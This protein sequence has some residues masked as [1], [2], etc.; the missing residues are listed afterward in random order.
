[1]IT[2]AQVKQ[3]ALRLW[4][5]DKLLRAWL[6]CEALFPLVIG[7]GKPTATALL[8]DFSGV[9]AWKVDLEKHSQ[10]SIGYGYRIEYVDINHRQLGK[11][12][13][14]SKLVFDRPEDLIAYIKK[15]KEISRF[16]QL[17]GQIKNT[18]RKLLQWCELHP[19]KVLKYA[20]DWLRLLSVV[21]FFKE[22]PQPNRY[23]RELDIPL[24]DSKFIEK[25]KKIISQL[26]ERVLSP[27]DVD[28]CIQGMTNSGFERRF[29]LRYDQPNIRLRLLDEKLVAY[30]GGVSDLSIPL[31]QFVAMVPACKRVFITENKI[32]G[33]TFPPLSE[34][35]V[36]FGL[37]YGISL[38]KDIDWLMHRE[39]I[40]WGDIDTHGFAILSQLRAYYPQAKSMLMDLNT[41]QQFRSSWVVEQDSKRCLSVLPNLTPDEQGLLAA[42]KDNEFG[43]NIRLEQ[44]RVWFSTLLEYLNLGDLNR[45]E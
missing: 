45:A 8:N 33:L 41:L 29:G 12:R 36:I 14:P 38:L 42:L 15:G 4:Q 23:I 1:M 26:L 9:R 19:S 44:E 22:N 40:Y 43:H 16:S 17:L 21:S 10:C 28:Q 7:V 32:N 25:N 2:A 20:D 27:S 11:H 3:K 31:S 18:D 6:G 13:L 5:N 39:I 37:G 30:Y 24:V 34:S 35:I